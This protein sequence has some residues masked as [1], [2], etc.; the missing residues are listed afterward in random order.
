MRHILS[1]ALLTCLFINLTNAQSWEKEV[2]N[3]GEIMKKA[4]KLHDDEKYDEA[5]E[6]NNLI[7]EG[8][9]NYQLSLY[10]RS[11]SYYGLK[12]YDECIAN[13]EKTLEL[14]SFSVDATDLM[15]SAY[16]DKGESEKAL[17]I[18]E[19]GIKRFPKNYQIRYNMAVTYQKLEKFDKSTEFYIEALKL[20]PFHLGS[21]IQLGILYH[22]EGKLT[23]ATLLLIDAILFNFNNESRLKILVYL[24]QL[25]TEKPSYQPKGVK[26]ADG[27][28]S[29]SEID[30]LLKSQ[31]AISKKYKT[32]S[33]LELD[34]VKQIHLMLTLLKDYKGNKNG[35]FN[36]YIIPFHAEVLK[37][38]LFPGYSYYIC[39]SS[40]SKAVEKVILG[41]K[42]D[43]DTYVDYFKTDGSEL[44]RDIDG[45][46]RLFYEY[47]YPILA[48]G[49][50][51]D[52]KKEGLWTYYNKDG[53]IMSYGNYKNDEHDGEWKY[54]FADGT[55]NASKI[56]KEDK[57][58]GKYVQYNKFGHVSETGEQ[59]DDN[60][61]GLVKV[62]NPSGGLSY[63]VEMTNNK[64]NGQ[65][66]SYYA[67]G[68]LAYETEY[69]DGKENGES[70][71]Y[72]PNGKLRFRTQVVKDE[73]QGPYV[74]YFQDGKVNYEANYLDDEIDGPYK[75]YYT[76]G[77]L[78][79]EG[80][81]KAGKS[82]GSLKTYYSNGN[83]KSESVFDESSK[84][85]GIYK[86]Y[87][88]D[89]IIDYQSEFVKG[90]EISYICYDKSGK[91]IVNQKLKK[92]TP[93][94]F[95]YST[96]ELL[97]EGTLSSGAKE[98]QWKFYYRN[99]NLK[100]EE[101]YKAGQLDGS[102][103]YYF[104][105]GD[106]RVELGYKDG[107]ESCYAK[108]YNINGDVSAEGRFEDGKREGP[109]KH[110]NMQKTLTSYSF[111]IHGEVNGKSYSYDEVGKLRLVSEYELDNQTKAIYYDTSGTIVKINDFARM[112]TG[113]TKVSPANPLE[114]VSEESYLLY[115]GSKE[116][117]SYGNFAPGHPEFEGNYLNNQR[118]GEWKWYNPDGS[119][120]YIAHYAYEDQNGKS[121]TYDDFGNMYMEAN[122]LNNE[123]D[124]LKKRYYP[125]GS[126]YYTEE[127][128]LGSSNGWTH[129]YGSNNKVVLSLF[130]ID[131]EVIKYVVNEHD[132]LAVDKGNATITAK[133]PNG[134]TAYEMTYKNG[135]LD[136]A[137]KSYYEN[138]ELRYE[139]SFN[140]DY[141]NGDRIFYYPANKIMIK[142]AYIMGDKQGTHYRYDKNGSKMYEINYDRDALH[143]NYIKY[144]TKTN[145][146]SLRATFYYDTLI[147]YE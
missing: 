93:A 29:F 90:E 117:K 125:D 25:L 78:R 2:I 115:N 92:N 146:P 13:C 26:F 89:G 122:Y 88:I 143:G 141:L 45:V 120:N 49:K 97:S 38:N 73:K 94:K 87:D 118:D 147:K 103:R 21:L 5:I 139:V 57:G 28:E 6:Q 133:Y 81:K 140:K 136:G 69:V 109:W 63:T 110:Y 96:G 3:S 31:A 124:G 121:V 40:D 74:F 104:Q 99:G 111:Y 66:K 112:D 67:N 76:N 4:L 50:K 108:Y 82:V 53:N 51:V 102:C 54:F 77:V 46:S 123:L 18:Y 142:Q 91:E 64:R 105:N 43:L 41:G 59:K 113:F 62:Y 47:P 32:D 55:L 17:R 132:T 100:S 131:N 135:E 30:D 33:K 127:Y 144:D 48:E 19:A 107:Q 16:D 24:N 42:K 137:Y 83:L 10:E 85:N 20:N 86:L 35:F 116:G 58:N 15:A 71:S 36:K 27:D 75:L 101:N 98:G 52:G 68:Q 84:Q 44:V 60:Y 80:T 129:Y 39:S 11:L 79:E 23:Q 9:T 61:N 119:S 1:F 130:T 56:F 106:L 70:V 7:I 95:Y 126:V 128:I 114:S 72:Y 65:M 14:D 145:K 34:L 138:G 37:R 22:Q 12:K 134:K 8:D